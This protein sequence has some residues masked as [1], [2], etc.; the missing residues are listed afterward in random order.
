MDEDR[1][2]GTK[3]TLKTFAAMLKPTSIIALALYSS[4]TCNNARGDRDMDGITEE[5]CS[6]RG[7]LIAHLSYII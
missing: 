1:D 2:Y 6:S 7:T 5:C 4:L 3:L